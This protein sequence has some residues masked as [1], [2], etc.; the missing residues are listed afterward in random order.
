MKLPVTVAPRNGLGRCQVPIKGDAR[1]KTKADLLVSLKLV[2]GLFDE[3]WP[4]D[5]VC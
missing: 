1:H 4:S 2:M 5:P 3:G